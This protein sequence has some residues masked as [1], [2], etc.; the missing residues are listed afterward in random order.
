[1]RSLLGDGKTSSSSLES[2]VKGEDELSLGVDSVNMQSIHIKL[3][4]M[5]PELDWF[6]LHHQSGLLFNYLAARV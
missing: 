3:K 2:S 6:Q 1:M 5:Y 4:L